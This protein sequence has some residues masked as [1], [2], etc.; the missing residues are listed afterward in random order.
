[1][2]KVRPLAQ[3]ARLIPSGITSGPKETGPHVVVDAVNPPSCGGKKANHFRPDQSAGTGYENYLSHWSIPSKSM[4]HSSDPDKRQQP[5]I[6]SQL[7]RLHS[8]RR[9]G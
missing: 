2:G 1:M 6:L 3:Q 4:M 9:Q 7:L 5:S 8:S